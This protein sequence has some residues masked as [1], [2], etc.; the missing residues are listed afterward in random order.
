M[1]KLMW[2]SIGFTAACVV[3]AYLL[4]GSWL[5][6][7]G[8][9]CLGCVGIAFSVPSLR[10][11][12]PHYLLIGC[13]LGLL[14]NWGYD[15]LY[16]S[17]ARSHHGKAE[18]ICIE[19]TDYST[20]SDYG[21]NAVGKVELD[22][23][24]YTIQFY[25]AQNTPLS[26]GD[27]VE[28][29]FLLR[30][31]GF[32]DNGN[33]H[34]GN[35]VFLLANPKGE[36]EI[37]FA[38][39]ISNRYLPVVIRHKILAILETTFPEDTRA[40]AQALLV[41]E[42]SELSYEIDSALKISGIRHVVAVSG[43]HVSILF[44]LVYLLCGKQRLLTMLIGLPA[45]F[46]FAAIAG[47]SPSIVRAC[48]MQALMILALL[49]NKE[50]DPPTALSFAVLVLLLV[51]PGAITSV[52][53]QL[54]AGCMIGIFLFAEPI[55]KYLLQ[56]K[57]LGTAKGKSLKARLA[58]WLA[59][60]VSVTLGAMITTTPLC[61]WYFGTVSLAG[62]LT[63][64]L[65]LWL[66]SFVFY[67]LLA[68][69]ILGAVWLP[70]GNLLAWVISWPIRF[71]LWVA[72][73]I[74]RVPVSSVYTCSVYIVI[75]LILC[76]VL[77]M[78]F[79]KHKKHPV[80][81]ASCMVVGLVVALCLSWLEP[82]LDNYRITAVD[83]GQGQCLILQNEGKYYMVDCGGDSD[84]LAADRAT[85]LLYSQGVFHLDGIIVTHYDK[86]HAGGVAN[87]MSR[88]ST[89]TLYLPIFDGEN[90]LKDQLTA[91]YANKI[92]WVGEMQALS[93]EDCLLTIIPSQNRQ[94]TNESSLC[95]LFQKPNC[96]ILITGDRSNEGEQE[97]L[98]TVELPDIEIL[99]AGHHGSATSTSWELL[100]ATTP[101]IVLISVG[102]GNRY[103]HPKEE[104][105]ERLNLFDCL[106]YRTDLEGTLIFRG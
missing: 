89:D 93:L 95:V 73:M 70:L 33:Y 43:L 105:L 87:L 56:P 37:T 25:L 4:D 78:V 52:S 39:K 84:Q 85:Q 41:G 62:I 86:D 88:I 11:K 10:R 1:R 99:V 72:T 22:G 100:R 40:F 80:L 53:L 60:S 19:V 17:A 92:Q 13:A 20:P 3:C 67:G 64:F 103:G 47:F 75:W 16:L 34:R 59:G 76:Y 18:M 74:S 94:D 15:R 38:D 96:D 61:A 102:E 31:T 66:I 21:V 90:E 14:W 77:L 71:V 23:K 104:T 44:A 51:N 83:V 57:R 32:V 106:V 49:L 5:L 30:Y 97:L 12:I 27:L 45:L 48:I 24:S 42:T 6:L 58:R 63:N 50:Y 91:K 81:M 36:I 35:G 7:L 79:R 54:S 68:T 101:E 2:F 69:C 46:L 9:L 55:R 8:L 65:T 29:G 28:G 26:P 98:D 82:R